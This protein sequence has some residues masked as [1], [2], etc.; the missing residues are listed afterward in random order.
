MEKFGK[1]RKI[2]IRTTV[3]I[4][5]TPQKILKIVIKNWSK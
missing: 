1:F 2:G 5:P 3:E 4:E